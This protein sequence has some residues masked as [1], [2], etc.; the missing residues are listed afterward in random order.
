VPFFTATRPFFSA[1]DF[2]F[3]RFLSVFLRGA[4]RPFSS[5]V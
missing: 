2:V 5:N 1:T 4:P 3:I